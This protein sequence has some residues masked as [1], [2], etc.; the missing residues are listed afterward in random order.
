MNS[1]FVAITFEKKKPFWAIAISVLKNSYEGYMIN[2]LEVTLHVKPRFVGVLVN[3]GKWV[4]I[5]NCTRL[6][7]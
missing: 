3:D 1:N 6:V 7:L 5:Y 2:Y 4:R